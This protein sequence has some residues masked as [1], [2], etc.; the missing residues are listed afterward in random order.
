LAKQV[1]IIHYHVPYQ[2]ADLLQTIGRLKKPYI[3]T[4]HSDI[5]KQKRLMMLYKPLM[6][7]LLNGAKYILPTS[8]NYLENS[9]TLREIK[10]PK[11]VI[12]MSLNK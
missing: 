10:V 12:P 3:V 8:P 2:Y 1:D 11:T 9:E 5:I 4:Y 6:K 7:R